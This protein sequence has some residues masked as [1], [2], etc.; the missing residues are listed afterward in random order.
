[1]ADAVGVADSQDTAT[2]YGRYG[3]IAKTCFKIMRDC[4]GLREGENVVI[5]TD[6]EVSPLIP[7]GFR[8]ATHILGG[9][10]ATVMMSPQVVH[11]AEPPN[12]VAAAMAAADIIVAPVSRS[13]THTKAKT[14]IFDRPDAKV[15][16][17]GLSSITEDAMIHGAATADM[18]EVNRIGE[19]LAKV[20]RTGREV[21]ITSDFGTDVTFALD[22][23]RLVK[24]ANGIAREPGV[25]KMFPDGEVTQSPIEESVEGVIV[26]DRWMQGIGFIQ[27]KP[28][29]WEFKKGRCVSISG[30][31]EAE[32]LKRVIEEEGDE[33]SYYI[34]EFAVGINPK[35]RITGNPH[36]E[37][38]KVMGHVHMALG[39]GVAL[40]G[41]FRSAL[42]LD[43]VQL[44]PVVYVDGKKVVE[45][46]KILVA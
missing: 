33:Y 35:A 19:A 38:K 41:K 11:G 39:T 20:F 43:G 42:H 44:R 45:G 36:R 3:D 6:T 12:V 23:S 21:R 8:A 40:G 7:E 29:Q 37:G 2:R 18:D 13:I 27:D 15:R 9:R 10:P 24:V 46:G 14:D 1:M 22:N 32:V 26:I 31:V 25:A 17:I 4:F 34:G 30:G 28:I 5:V 16:Y